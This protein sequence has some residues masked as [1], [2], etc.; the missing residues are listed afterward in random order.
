MG[1]KP[2]NAVAIALGIVGGIIF[3]GMS[4]AAKVIQDDAYDDIK[5]NFKEWMDSRKEAEKE[6]EESEA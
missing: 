3:G 2:R 6:D 5:T 1:L 4:G